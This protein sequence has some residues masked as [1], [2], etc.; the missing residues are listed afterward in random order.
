MSWAAQR[1]AW[2]W[3]WSSWRGLWRRWSQTSTGRSR[4]SLHSRAPSWPRDETGP[5]RNMSCVE[6]ELISI[7]VFQLFFKKMKENLSEP[8]DCQAAL[9]VQR[10]R[11][12]SWWIRHRKAQEESPY[13][14]TWTSQ[15]ENTTRPQKSKMHQPKSL[16]LLKEQIKICGQYKKK[17][18]QN[19]TRNRVGHNKNLH[20]C[21]VEP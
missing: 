19:V 8:W 10:N 9:C 16:I 7:S 5:D 2:K 12:S 18:I 6:P 4:R 1:R 17:L 14:R 3:R 20:N 13:P 21:H 15:P 11:D